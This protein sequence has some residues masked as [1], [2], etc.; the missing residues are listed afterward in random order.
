MYP[1]FDWLLMLGLQRFMW[2]DW[3]V[4]STRELI[5]DRDAVQLSV[6]ILML[7]T[8]GLSFPLSPFPS[9]SLPTSFYSRIFFYFW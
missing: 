2:K 7:C 3:H 9:W 6:L 8:Q 5:Y 4:E 1:P